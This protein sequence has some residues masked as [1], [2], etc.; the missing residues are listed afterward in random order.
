MSSRLAK[1]PRSFPLQ[2]K[3]ALAYLCLTIADWGKVQDLAS[4][5][6]RW[7]SSLQ[8]E[9]LILTDRMGLEVEHI[10]FGSWC[11]SRFY[12][13]VTESFF[14]AAVRGDVFS[15]CAALRCKQEMR[16]FPQS[17]SL[18]PHR[19]DCT[20]SPCPLLP[21]SILPPSLS[22][23]VTSTLPLFYCV[24]FFTHLK[25]QGLLRKHP[26]CAQTLTQICPRRWLAQLLFPNQKQTAINRAPSLLSHTGESLNKSVP[27]W[28]SAHSRLF[29]SFSG[30]RV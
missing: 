18:S 6:T 30:S 29:Y 23:T 13:L 7:T 25:Y 8:W 16:G 3:V 11:D 19:T 27:S 24:S 21:S 28:C 12:S 10:N 26:S 4:S 14:Q 5:H 17:K 1:S 15:Q 22:H 9:H 20:P 2:D